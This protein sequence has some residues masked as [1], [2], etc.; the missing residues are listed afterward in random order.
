MS[1]IVYTHDTGVSIEVGR[2]VQQVRTGKTV[3]GPFE[4]FDVE[5]TMHAIGAHVRQTEQVSLLQ[6]AMDWQRINSDESPLEDQDGKSVREK[7][8]VCSKWVGRDTPCGCPRAGARP[9]PTTHFE[10]THLH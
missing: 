8:W 10:C 2:V 5:E 1:K 4:P 3:L 6:A 7:K 9:T